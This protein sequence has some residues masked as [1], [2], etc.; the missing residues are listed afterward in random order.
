M[1][2]DMEYIDHWT[3]WLDFKILARTIPAVIKGRGAY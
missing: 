1:Q 2:L 3:L